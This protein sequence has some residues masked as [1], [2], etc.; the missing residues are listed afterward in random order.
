MIQEQVNETIWRLFGGAERAAKMSFEQITQGWEVPDRWEELSPHGGM[1]YLERLSDLGFDVEV[2]RA[3]AGARYERTHLGRS[4]KTIK[5]VHSRWFVEIE[6][7]GRHRDEEDAIG[8][9]EDSF[10]GIGD[11]LPAALS[12]AMMDLDSQWAKGRSIRAALAS[13]G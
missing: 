11:T 3:H 4:G 9:P 10:F 6:F 1:G 7:K 5:T 8:V 2:H 12:A 13:E